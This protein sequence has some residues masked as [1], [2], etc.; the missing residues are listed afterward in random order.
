MDRQD[1]VLLLLLIL[2]IGSFIL[3]GIAVD[4]TKKALQ[5]FIYLQ[6]HPARLI[7]DFIEIQS[8]GAAL[9]NAAIVG[10]IGLALVVFSK[11][12]LSG[13]TFAA[14]FT[15]MGFGLFGKT[16]LNIVPII[17][18]VYIAAKL[19]GKTLREYMLIALFGTALG[20]L[21]SLIAFET[22]LSG[23]AALGVSTAAGVVTGFLLPAIAVS[24]LHLHQGYNLYNMGLSCG[25]FGLFTAALIRAAGHSLGT[26]TKWYSGRS[27]VLTLLVPVLSLVLILI[28]FLSGG[29]KSIGDLWAIQKHSGRLPSDFMDMESMAGAMI[30]SGLIGLAGSTY[31]LLIGGDFNGPVLG[32]LLTITGFGAFGTHLRNSWPIALGVILSTLLFGKPL[33][34]P[35]PILAAIFCTTLAPLAGQFGIAAGLAAGFLHLVL[36]LQAGS[37][38]AGMNLYNNGFAGGLTAT[39]IV[40]VIQWYR[41]NR[42][43]LE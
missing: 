33:A 11:V 42:S 29:K 32:G 15:L 6:T 9:I 27:M 35:G 12:Q 30:N 13:P 17:A 34:S 37:W 10:G 3:M 4:G 14:I 31:V 22:R 40:S 5:G 39:L 24:M 1:K 43:D 2:I 28:G 16:P 23:I 36:V 26:S 19:A 38:H 21:V 20:P 18:G 7:N 8:I 41:T 25:F